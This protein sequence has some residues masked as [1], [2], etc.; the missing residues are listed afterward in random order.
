[1]TQEDIEAT[2]APLV[3]HLIELRA[4]LIRALAVLGV[5]FVLCFVFASDLFNILLYP[6]ERA[7]GDVKD[8]QLIYTAPQEYFFTQMKIALFGGVFIAFPVIAAEIY[9]FVA[10]GLYRDERRAFLPYLMAT[11][12]LFLLGAM[13][14]YFV[15]MPLAMGFFLS[16]EQAGGEGAA[17]I[18]L[19]ARV[20]EYL[21]LIMTLILAFGI[22]FQLPVIL[23]LLARIGVVDAAGL[24]AKRKYAIIAVFAVA[25]FLTPPDLISQIGLALPTLALYEL[26]IL[27]V[28]MVEKK[29]AEAN[30]ATAGGE[31]GGGAGK[32][33]AAEPT[34]DIYDDID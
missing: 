20:S 1:M 7:V 26:A 12:V 33:A 11:P 24:R 32:A 28:R 21:G 10:P 22:C 14:V 3:T 31:A 2:R 4:R 8:V 18:Q 16:M 13:L 34:G 25:A 29:Q 5:A 19:V 27:A 9:R 6:Y 23:T 17:S 15:I 30:A